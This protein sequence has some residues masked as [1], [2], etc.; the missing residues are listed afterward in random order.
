MF[1]KCF[2]HKQF[3]QA[4]GIAIE[5]RRED[6][7]EKAITL[8]DDR[9][10]MLR[11]AL[12]TVLTLVDSVKLR[13]RL[14]GILVQIYSKNPTPADSVHI[15]QCLVLMDNAKVILCVSTF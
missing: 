8:A 2:H 5:T 13:N 3:K 9:D 10:D 4:L 7:F 1:N 11:Y 15:C 12:K 14:L 6:I